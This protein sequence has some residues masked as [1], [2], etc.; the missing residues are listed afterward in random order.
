MLPMW[1][2]LPRLHQPAYKNPGPLAF[3]GEVW[4]RLSPLHTARLPRNLKRS[5]ASL[6]SLA[7]C[8]AP[9]PSLLQ[10]HRGSQDR[11][12]QL[13]GSCSTP[14]VQHRRLF[15]TVG[16]GPGSPLLPSLTSVSPWQQLEVSSDCP[17]PGRELTAPHLPLST[18]SFAFPC[19]RCQEVRRP[20]RPSPVRPSCPPSFWQVWKL[21][22]S[23]G[24]RM[25]RTEHG[26]ASPS[27]LRLLS[28]TS[29]D[30]PSRPSP[31]LC[32]W[33]IQTK[34][35]PTAAPG[36]LGWTPPTRGAWGRAASCFTARLGWAQVAESP[37]GAAEECPKCRE[38]RSPQ[39][40]TG[41]QM[42]ST[43]ARECS[44][45]WHLKSF[46]GQSPGYTACFPGS[47]PERAILAPMSRTG[48]VRQSVYQHH[49]AR[50]RNTTQ[51]SVISISRALA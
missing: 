27:S 44:R 24:R 32:F 6:W 51:V 26:L 8:P 10:P 31:Q 18:V 41:L 38:K 19:T 36:P 42:G 34:I 28:G 39:T 7:Q 46:R 21:Q 50:P 12:E 3:G 1:Q 48:K 11:K 37:A 45:M 47:K 35:A 9:V 25:S 2:L 17:G 33:G 4:P 30:K 14:Q 16:E 23:P 5:S 49:L 13:P 43:Q 15:L 40:H 29:P 20:R 22:R